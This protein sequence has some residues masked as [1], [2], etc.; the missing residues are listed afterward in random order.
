MMDIHQGREVKI[1]RNLMGSLEGKSQLG[2]YRCKWEDK[3]KR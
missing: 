3:A 1:S 2:I